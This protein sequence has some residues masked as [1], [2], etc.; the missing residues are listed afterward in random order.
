MQQAPHLFA[1]MNTSRDAPNPLRPY[2]IPPSIGLPPDAAPSATAAH[3]RPSAAPSTSKPSFGTSARDILSDL[4]YGDSIFSDESPSAA[5]MAKKLLDQAVWKYTSVLLAQPFEVAKT[6]LQVHV[7]AGAGAGG[8]AGRGE[9]MR[10]HPGN[11]RDPAYEDNSISDTDSDEEPSYFTTSAPRNTSPSRSPEAR[12][13]RRRRGHTPPPRSQSS[14]PTPT[15]A[16]PHPSYKL[17]LRRPDSL[18][19]VLSQ[20][21]AKEGAWG[22]WK[23]TNATFVYSVLLKTIESWTRSLLS[24]L[25][26]LPDPGLLVGS[27]GAGADGLGV[28][29]LDIVDSPSPLASLGIAVA[30]AGIAGLVL[31]PLDIV[32]TRLILT[33]PTIHPRALLPSLRALPSLLLPPSLLPITLLHSTLPTLLTTTTPLFLRA[34]L[35]IDP[36]LTP[37]LYSLTTFISSALELAIKLPLETV[38]RRGQADMLRREGERHR[39]DSFKP[40]SG[41]AGAGVFRGDDA[42]AF[43]TIVDV[44]LY[45]GV[46][47]T[48]W[49]IVREE[50]STR[51]PHP[52]VAGTGGAPATARHDSANRRGQGLPGLWRG[53]RVG[54]WGLLGVWGA[55]AMGGAAGAGGGEF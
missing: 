29:G 35:R 43:R 40:R 20:L 53:W 46:L 49:H 45:K 1:T 2:Y 24:A 17:E 8:A 22:V 25:L 31:A 47:G 34:N 52:L 54:M 12:R 11:Y 33:P 9:S 51:P 37:S 10:R 15:S 5:E 36:L 13:H 18:L 39:L 32:R 44:G 30:A 38:L 26:N 42:D 3:S 50:G 28:G 23:G 48:L 19:D 14:T 55:A 6:V 4:D 16:S 21:W 41:S 7:A 27:V